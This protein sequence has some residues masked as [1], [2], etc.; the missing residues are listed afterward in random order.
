MAGTTFGEAADTRV[1]ARQEARGFTER[2]ATV[3]EVSRGLH[4]ELNCRA[5]RL[6]PMR[7][8]ALQQGQCHSS[9]QAPSGCGM[10]VRSCR[11]TASREDLLVWPAQLRQ[12]IVR[13]LP[14]VPC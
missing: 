1:H 14:F 12:L 2:Y 3:Y 4:R 7:M 5:V 13:I 10:A 8:S 11:A 6:G 9:G